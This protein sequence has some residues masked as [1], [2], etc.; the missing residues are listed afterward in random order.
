MRAQCRLLS[1]SHAHAY[2][3][4][5]PLVPGHAVIASRRAE[6]LGPTDLA[7]MEEWVGLWR[8]AHEAQVAAEAATGAAASTLL[9]REG[10][11]AAWSGAPLHVHVLPRRPGDFP[12]NDDVFAAMQAWRPP[13]AAPSVAASW[14]LE[15]PD[16]DARRDRAFAEMAD[17]AASYRDPRARPVEG[18]RAFAALT[19][20]RD[21]VFYVSP[22]GLSHA[23][24]NLRP[25]VPGHVLVSP[26]RVVPRTADLSP[27]ERDDLWA[28]ALATR[29]LVLGRRGGAATTCELGVQDG[30]EAGQ[31]VPHVH[32]HVSPRPRAGAL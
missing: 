14:S 32:V 23:F 20:P 25:L 12:K 16:G 17:E 18:D 5:N 10:P 27:E 21:H 30:A 13:D 7:G 26:R 9:M 28:S 31:S 29:R 4:L 15:V 3:R 8:L 22:T 1:N 11:D 24:V 19:I 2:G 6:V